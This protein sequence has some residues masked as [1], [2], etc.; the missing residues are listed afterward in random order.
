MGLSIDIYFLICHLK[1]KQQNEKQTGA[2][3]NQK[4]SFY[5]EK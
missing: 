4:V 3:T 2:T 5:T 1:H